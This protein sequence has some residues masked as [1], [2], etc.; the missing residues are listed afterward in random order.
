MNKKITITVILVAVILTLAF[1]VWQLSLVNQKEGGQNDKSLKQI[2][3]KEKILIGVSIPFE[4]MSFKDSKDDLAGFDI[5]LAKAI[6]DKIKVKPEYKVMEFPDIFTALKKGQIDLAISAITITPKRTEDYLFSENY[7]TTGQRIVVR[8]DNNVIK[9]KGDLEGKKVGVQKGTTGEEQAIKYAGKE[10]V[11]SY[12]NRK[13]IEALSTNFIDAIVT[14][15][16]NASMIIKNNPNLKTV[17][18]IFSKERY[19]VMARL[20]DRATIQEV[21]RIIKT[22]KTNGTMKKLGA[23]WGLDW[24]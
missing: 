9:S 6:A 14:D 24:Q 1:S 2:K 3:R 17:G 20:S 10:N 8:K 18:D 7:I 22:M 4:P 21:N 12:Q 15:D 16:I 11:I 23:K 19:G 5:D 13:E